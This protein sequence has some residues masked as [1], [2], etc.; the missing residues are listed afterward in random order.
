MQIGHRDDLEIAFVGPRIGDSD[1]AADELAE[2]ATIFAADV[3]LISGVESGHLRFA[4]RLCG[5]A[6]RRAGNC[7]NIGIGGKHPFKIRIHRGFGFAGVDDGIHLGNRLVDQRSR[8]IH[9]QRA[10][11]QGESQ[12]AHAGDQSGA[13]RAAGQE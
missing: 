12:I 10:H 7:R 11:R 8:L 1:F 6:Q 13:K 3:T 5:R 2:A 4:G 9:G